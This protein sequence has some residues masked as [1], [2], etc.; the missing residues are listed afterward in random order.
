MRE[1]RVLISVSVN[2]LFLS[3]AASIPAHVNRVSWH[4]GW[5]ED[6]TQLISECIFKNCLALEFLTLCS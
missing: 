2:S 4:M 5:G 3:F 6:L 1:N